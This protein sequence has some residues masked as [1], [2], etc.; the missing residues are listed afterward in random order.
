MALYGVDR[1]SRRGEA[2]GVYF[3][4]FSRISVFEARDAV[5]GVR[6]P[7]SGLP[8]VRPVRGTVPLLM[9]MIGTVS[10]DGFTNKRTWNSR[11]PDIAEFFQDHLSLTPEHSLELTFLLGMLAMVLFVSSFY[12]LGILGA[13]SAG[14]GFSAR[15]LAGQFVHSLV[16]IAAAYVGAHY[17]TLLL[18][19]GQSLAYLAS[20]PLG[21]GSNILGTAGWQVHYGLIGSSVEWYVKV[22]MIVSGHVAGLILAHDR[23]VAIYRDARQAVR[24]QYWMLG[25]MLGFTMLAIWLVSESNT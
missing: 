19:Q 23:A 6:K 12:W 15:E 9:V 7:L 2:F 8:Q 18:Y 20:D 24:S 5:V 17:F 13:R 22:A 3:N 4:L 11:S 25:V 21:E 1:W 16:P 14:G 10:F